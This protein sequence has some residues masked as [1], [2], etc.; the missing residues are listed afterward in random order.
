MLCAP[1]HPVRA[2]AGGSGE[3]ERPWN[4]TPD[5]CGASGDRASFRTAQGGTCQACSGQDSSNAQVCIGQ[6]DIVKQ[7]LCYDV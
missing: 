2:E 4:T 5:S 3:A 7:P 1:L 6:H